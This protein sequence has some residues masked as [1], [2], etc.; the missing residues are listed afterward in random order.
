MYS[1]SSPKWEKRKG[2]RK[3]EF[4]L[5]RQG[6]KVIQEASRIIFRLSPWWFQWT[7]SLQISS[8][9]GLNCQRSKEK[10]WLTYNSFSLIEIAVR[11]YNGVLARLKWQ[12]TAIK[13][14]HGVLAESR[15]LRPPSRCL[16]VF[17]LFVV[18]IHGTSGTISRVSRH[19]LSF[20]SV[21][22][23]CLKKIVRKFDNWAMVSQ[24]IRNIIVRAK[25]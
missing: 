7:S 23:I 14:L 9:A 19:I 4:T 10:E 25:K 12:I 3:K 8:L 20:V 13:L 21:F 5:Q 22:V 2:T 15:F 11:R 16:G 18:R 24:F 17:L 6:S 1:A